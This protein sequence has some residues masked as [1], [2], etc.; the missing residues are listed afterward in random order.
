MNAAEK[1]VKIIKLNDERRALSARLKLCKNKPLKKLI[2][3]RLNKLNDE[4]VELTYGKQS[5]RR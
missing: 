1:E 4:I 5:Y 3:A 2:E